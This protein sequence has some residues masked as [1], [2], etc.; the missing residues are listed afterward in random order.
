MLDWSFRRNSKNIQQLIHHGKVFFKYVLCLRAVLLCLLFYF[1]KEKKKHFHI[2]NQ[3]PAQQCLC[4]SQMQYRQLLEENKYSFLVFTFFLVGPAKP[5]PPTCSSDQFP[6]AYV[7]QCLPLS[8]KCNGAEDCVDGS[9]EINCPT[10]TPTTMSPSSCKPTE[11]LCPSK[12][13]I[14]ALLKCDGV[15]DCLLNE[16][17]VG[18][19]KLISLLYLQPC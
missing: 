12:G 4:S 11:F 2:R 5:Q 1:K 7:Q 18:C 13:C 19:R 15:P 16:D 6:C 9:D 10:M 8:A 17:E 14:P 3:L